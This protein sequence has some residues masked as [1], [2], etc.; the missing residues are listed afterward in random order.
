M[1]CF[2]HEHPLRTLTRLI[3]TTKDVLDVSSW[4]SP[5]GN[6]DSHSGWSVLYGAQRPWYKLDAQT[7]V[8]KMVRYDSKYLRHFLATS[9]VTLAFFYL[10]HNLS[11]YLSISP[12]LS[13]SPSLLSSLLSLSLSL[14]LPPSL[15]LS[16]SSFSVPL[17][18][19]SPS[20][21]LPLPFSLS[22]LW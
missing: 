2:Q 3:T 13:L 17:P 10:S 15:S 7:Y 1:S 6:P 8:L 18:S 19:L 22:P 14:S 12:P 21:P 5:S 9:T 11:L 4:C 20:L 16:P